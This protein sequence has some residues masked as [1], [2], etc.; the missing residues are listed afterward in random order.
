MANAEITKRLVGWK[1]WGLEEMKACGDVAA[2]VP[3]VSGRWCTTY[4]HWVAHD[5]EGGG[6]FLVLSV[7]RVCHQHGDSAV[8]GMAWCITEEG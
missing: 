3:L 5:V 4:E 2:A 7:D 1:E 8:A 6:H